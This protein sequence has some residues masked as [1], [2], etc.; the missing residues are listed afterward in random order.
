MAGLG[1]RHGQI[2]R[3]RRLGDP[4]LLVGECDDLGLLLLHGV[5]ALGRAGTHPRPCSPG[6]AVVLPVSMV[7]HWDEVPWERA[8]H[9]ERLCW[10]RQRLTPGLS[11]YRVAAGDRIMPVH[12]HVDEEEIAVVLAGGGVSWQDG[13]TYAIRTGDARVHRPDA[14]AHTLIGGDGG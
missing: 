1:E 3:G 4:A 12:V 2:E 11:R 13:L 10:Q 6:S 8:D 9:G 14:E 5:L 7:V